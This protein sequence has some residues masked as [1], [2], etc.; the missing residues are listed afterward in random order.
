ML[1]WHQRSGADIALEMVEKTLDKMADGGIFDHLGGGFHR[2]SVD[3]Q[4]QVPH[5]EKMLYDQATIVYAYTEAFQISGKLQYAE[6]VASVVNYLER[7]LLDS[8]GVF[9]AAQ[10]ADSE[11][12]EGAFYVWTKAQIETVLGE[13]EGKFFC[14]HYGVSEEGNFPEIKG[15]SVLR[16]ISGD[17]DGEVGETSAELER[18]LEK[19]RQAL[20]K[21][22]AQ[23]PVPFIDKKVITAWNGLVIAALARASVVFKEPSYL[24]LAETAARALDKHP[25]RE[26]DQLFRCWSVGE[27]GAIPAFLDDYAFFIWGLLELDTAGA[28]PLFLE[29]AQGL[30]ATVNHLFW[31][32][33]GE[34]YFYSAS[35]AEKLIARNLELHDGVLPGSNSVMIMNL[36]RL[37]AKTGDGDLQKQ[38]EKALGRI[39]GLAAQTPLLYLQY[40]NALDE[41]LP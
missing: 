33:Q 22:R 1:R 29:R 41:Y 5:F 26:G 4:W 20:L 12:V 21:A 27:D 19:S 13:S 11:G 16:R 35:D 37:A 7:D 31:D 2:Y 30:T 32:A 34:R 24:V 38:A 39:A 18:K 23:R 36:L 10:D 3:S 17:N 40:L 8:K 25:G 9:Y 28:D 6:V 15:S 14:R